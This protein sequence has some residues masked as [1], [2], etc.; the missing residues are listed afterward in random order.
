MSSV[1]I[2]FLLSLQGPACKHSNSFMKYREANR[3]KK[4]LIEFLSSEGIFIERSNG[5]KYPNAL[6]HQLTVVETGG[7]CWSQTACQK[8]NMKSFLLFR[9]QSLITSYSK[10]IINLLSSRAGQTA[11]KTWGMR[12]RPGLLCSPLGCKT[13]RPRENVSVQS[14]PHIAD[15]LCVRRLLCPVCLVHD[16]SRGTSYLLSISIYIMVIKL[17]FKIVKWR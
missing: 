4:I 15:M 6:L 10:H 11:L 16:R 9:F 5:S 14:C 3:K 12:D 7:E 13:Y 17:F 1:T 8:E 2:T